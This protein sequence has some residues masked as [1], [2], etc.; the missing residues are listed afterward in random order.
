MLN[1]DE[2]FANGVPYSTLLDIALMHCHTD[3]I[4]LL[5][6]LGLKLGNTTKQK[7]HEEM[8]LLESIACDNEE[9]SSYNQDLRKQKALFIK[10]KTSGKR[11][12]NLTCME[13]F[14]KKHKGFQFYNFKTLCAFIFLMKLAILEPQVKVIL[15]DK[16]SNFDAESAFN[17]LSK[18]LITRNKQM[19]D[20]IGQKVFNSLSYQLPTEII[21][22][23]VNQMLGDYWYMPFFMVSI[24][25][26]F[27]FAEQHSLGLSKSQ[28]L[29]LK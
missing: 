4:H 16:L 2:Q 25:S 3:M 17:I 27:L 23:I 28:R 9:K 7:L 8:N 20:E 10:F 12:L 14:L 11:V 1:S 26:K 21:D 29:I 5:I 15:A 18:F 13:V 22:I 19:S 6:I 24:G